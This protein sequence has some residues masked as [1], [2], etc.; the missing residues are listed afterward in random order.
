M[1]VASFSKLKWSD[2]LFVLVH[3]I[4]PLL[5]HVLNCLKSTVLDRVEQRRL[6]VLV[7]DIDVSTVR[8]QLLNCLIISFTYTIEYGSLTVDVDVIRIRSSSNKNVNNIVMSLA[9][10]VKKRELIQSVLL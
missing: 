2:L 8:N 6:S 7:D 1:F 10:C 5:Y 4:Y 3:N 9:H